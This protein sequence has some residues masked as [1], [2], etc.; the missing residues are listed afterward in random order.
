[1]LLAQAAGLKLDELE[2]FTEDERVWLDTYRAL[3]L[4]QRETILKVA[5]VMRRPS[6][7]K[8]AG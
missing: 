6:P 3:D 1:M 8:R 5:V 2:R 7:R 4:E